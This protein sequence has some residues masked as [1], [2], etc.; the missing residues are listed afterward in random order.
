MTRRLVA[1]FAK[2][3]TVALAAERTADLTAR[4]REVL[5]LAARGRARLVM[6]AYEAGL[7]TLGTP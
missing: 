6:A 5:I 7:T 4:E 2:R 3:S 1:E